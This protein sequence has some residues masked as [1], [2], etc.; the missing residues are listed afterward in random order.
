MNP[1]PKAFVFDMDGVL[2]DSH[3]AHR[4]AWRE[5]LRDEGFTVLA[6]NY[7]ESADAVRKFWSKLELEPAPLL[8]PDGRIADAYG[9]GLSSTGL[10]V[11]VF[12]ARDGSVSAF[13]PWALDP[14]YLSRQLKAIL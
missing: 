12:V 5:F 11:T 10:P 2:I 14:D 3:A 1:E 4:K 7:K 9:V 8:D 13:S 6:V